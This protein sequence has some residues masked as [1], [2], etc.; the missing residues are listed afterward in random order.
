LNRNLLLTLLLLNTA[1]VF[2]TT[3][4]VSNITTKTFVTQVE[5]KVI[6]KEGMLYVQGFEGSGEIEVYSLIG[7]KITSIVIQELNSFQFPLSLKAGNI[8]IV[9]VLLASSEVYTYKVVAI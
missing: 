8:Y 7:N 1:T 2:A 3:V 9:R 4:I 6:F 5:K